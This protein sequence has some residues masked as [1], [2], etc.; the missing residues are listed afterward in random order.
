M[1]DI[2]SKINNIAE[3]LDN[4]SSKAEEASK[5]VKDS[6]DSASESL[7]NLSNKTK[8]AS[9]DLTDVG[10]VAN[11]SFALLAATVKDSNPALSELLQ[12]TQ[13]LIPN[14]VDVG[15]K[16]QE[17]GSIMKGVF[18]STGILAL[19]TLVSTLITNFDSITEALGFSKEATT[20][21]KKTA[22]S[23]FKNVI[24]GVAGVG[25][26]ILQALLV[27]IKSAIDAFKGLASVVK[28]V[29]TGNWDQI[30]TDVSNAI[31]SINKNI[32]K[33]LSI[34]DNY[35][36]GSAWAS[37]LIDGFNSKEVETKAT[38]AGRRIGRRIGRAVTKGV[39]TTISS[40]SDDTAKALEKLLELSESYVKSKSL[41]QIAQNI[42]LVN[43]ALAST[44]DPE[45][46]S[47]L[48]EVLSA[49]QKQRDELNKNKELMDLMSLS[50]TYVKEEAI[51]NIEKSLELVNKEIESTL[52]SSM[53]TKL[54]EIRDK[55]KEQREALDIDPEVEKRK[56]QN[57]ELVSTWEQS[58][59]SD[60]EKLDQ[61][62]EQLK[63][64]GA[65]EVE[66]EKWYQEEKTKI[67]EAESEKRQKQA[68]DEFNRRLQLYTSTADAASGLTSSLADLLESDSKSSKKNAKAIKALK[69][70]STTIDMLSGAVKAYTAAQELGPII[71]PIVGAANAAAV[72][73]TG[74]AN[75]NK[76]KSVDVDSGNSA[77]PSSSA[78]GAVQGTTQVYSVSSSADTTKITDAIQTGTSKAAD[79]KVVLVV[80]DLNKVQDGMTQAD[81]EATI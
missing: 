26:T 17:S 4:L 50:S 19:I 66:L 40:S 34:K 23:V 12:S 35:R 16:A 79:T 45:R 44:S 25:N 8:Q 48:N 46:V 11:A 7:D 33:G 3:D 81:V 67:D 10:A 39:N 21:F 27:P 80:E 5:K 42:D 59:L 51:A 43:K 61:R 70:A 58:L 47:Q 53:L 62:Y 55:L 41:E 29:F 56:Q 64:A 49:L 13:T 6:I 57:E 18:S 30:G 74:I 20:E 38:S 77:T 22:L 76:I 68:E 1:S 9:V 72:V 65:N 32:K 71:G 36:T 15:K 14:L 78:V 31:G 73:A 69:I 54:E 75:I 2:D 52:D 63:D 24:A 28:D 37:R 60:Q